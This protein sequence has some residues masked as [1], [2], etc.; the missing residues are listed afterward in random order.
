M[1]EANRNSLG[2]FAIRAGFV[3]CL[4][5]KKYLTDCEPL[6]ARSMRA[7]LSG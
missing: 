1:F 2:S 7:M 4:A 6:H 3:R 5:V